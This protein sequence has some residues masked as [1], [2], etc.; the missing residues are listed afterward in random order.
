MKT[1]VF[2][3]SKLDKFYNVT[4]GKL[5]TP[6]HFFLGGIDLSVAV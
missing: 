2:V 5:D 1:I 3:Q 6:A 4:K